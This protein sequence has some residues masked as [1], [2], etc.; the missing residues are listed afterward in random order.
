MHKGLYSVGFFSIILLSDIS[1]SIVEKEQD[2]KNKKIKK[3]PYFL[4]KK[5]RKA[6]I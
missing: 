4:N 6:L 5:D 1:R 2:Q 3:T